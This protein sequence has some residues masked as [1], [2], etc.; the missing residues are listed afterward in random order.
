MSVPLAFVAHREHHLNLRIGRR[1]YPDPLSPQT[2]EASLSGPR[3]IDRPLRVVNDRCVN[4]RGPKSGPG[5]PLI[6]GTPAAS[7]GN[8]ARVVADTFN[9]Q[10]SRVNGDQPRAILPEWS[11]GM[12]P[13]TPNRRVTSPALGHA[14]PPG[15]LPASD[16]QPLAQR[17]P[18]SPFRYATHPGRRSGR[19]PPPERAIFYPDLVVYIRT[20]TD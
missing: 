11:G 16:L 20:K 13:G 17:A 1:G 7:T 18:R 2:S 6:T 15:R 4:A 9:N 3:T 10:L 5:S 8:P 19:R 14:R 12:A